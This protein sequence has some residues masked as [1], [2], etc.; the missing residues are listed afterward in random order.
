MACVGL[1]LHMRLRH[2]NEKFADA[3]AVQKWHVE[4]WLGKGCMCFLCVFVL[5]MFNSRVLPNAAVLA[6]QQDGVANLS[7]ESI[8]GVAF[9]Y[10]SRTRA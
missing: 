5:T 2:G 7:C 8:H 6:F 9:E 3:C 4:R 10:L 1:R